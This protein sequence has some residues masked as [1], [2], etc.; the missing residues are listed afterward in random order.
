MPMAG[1]DP[2]PTQAA[3]PRIPPPQLSSQTGKAWDAAFPTSGHSG[4][5]DS[6]PGYVTGMALLPASLG[7]LPLHAQTRQG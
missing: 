4:P 6:E 2:A 7:L 5:G 1:H 3:G